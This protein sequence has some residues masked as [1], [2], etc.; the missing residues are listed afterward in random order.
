MDAKWRQNPH[1]YKLEYFHIAV[2]LCYKII[3]WTF[4]MHFMFFECIFFVTEKLMS[5]NFYLHFFMVMDYFLKM[6]FYYQISSHS[7]KFRNSGIF[8]L[9]IYH[10]GF[11]FSSTTGK[12][13]DLNN[14]KFTTKRNWFHGD[15]FIYFWVVCCC[16]LNN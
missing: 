10:L 4:F 1:K 15:L 11:F 5:H 9:F 14:I 6:N 12:V 13:L 7:N 3:F 8:L 16:T 2:V